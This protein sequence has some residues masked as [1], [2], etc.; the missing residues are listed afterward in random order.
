[1][2]QVAASHETTETEDIEDLQL[3]YVGLAR[4][5]AQ[6]LRLHKDE[7][8]DDVGTADLLSSLGWELFQL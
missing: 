4:D 2:R 1:M 5:I 8:G 6:A 7:Y 3:Q